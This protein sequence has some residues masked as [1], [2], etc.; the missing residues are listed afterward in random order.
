MIALGDRWWSSGRSFSRNCGLI[1][2]EE[3][4]SKNKKIQKAREKY[5]HL[6]QDQVE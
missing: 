3:E 6:S 5:D 4:K 1:F 2:N